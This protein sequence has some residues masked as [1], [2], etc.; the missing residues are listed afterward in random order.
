MDNYT[1]NHFTDDD[2][3]TMDKL[4][5]AIDR[6]K[7]M[8]YYLSNDYIPKQDTFLVIEMYGD[9]V[10]LVHTDLLP[11][12]SEAAFANNCKLVDYK[13]VYQ[14]RLHKWLTDPERLREGLISKLLGF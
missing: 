4:L 13:T 5:E 10:I 11:V 1:N 14:E 7:T 3:L 9:K 12:L 6:L 2:N 8:V